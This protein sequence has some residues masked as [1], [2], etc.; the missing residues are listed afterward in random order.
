MMVLTSQVGG[1]LR[2]ASLQVLQT[3]FNGIRFTD[4][5]EVEHARITCDL[6]REFTP[7]GPPDDLPARS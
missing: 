2:D 5:G 6:G 1:D 3:A 7:A 4:G